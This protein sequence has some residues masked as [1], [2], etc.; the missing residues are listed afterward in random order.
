[1]AEIFLARANGLAGFERYVVLKRIRPER[2]ADPRWI[3]M[4]LDEARLAAQLQHPNVAQVYDLGQIGDAYFYTMEYVHGEDV[5]D[6]LSRTVA[7]GKKVPL[8]IAL[9]ITAGA[10]QGLGYAHDR[11]GVDGQPL[12]IVHRDIS[13]ANLMVSYDGT[14]K[15]LDFGVAKA[16][17]RETKTEAGTRMGKIAYLSP[18]Q[19]NTNDIDQR[20]DLFSLGVVLYEMVTHV[21]PF[22][23]Q[24]DYE[25]L[26]AIVRFDPPP[27]SA[28]VPG[29]PPEVDELLMKALAKDPNQRYLSAHDMLEGIEKAADAVKASLAPRDLKRFM[30]DLYGTPP[31]PWRTLA[32]EE[33]LPSFSGE[34]VGPLPADETRIRAFPA[35]ASAI[36]VPLLP[37]AVR[38]KAKGTPGATH[39]DLDDALLTPWAKFK[40]VPDGTMDLDDVLPTPIHSTPVP[41]M[42]PVRQLAYPSASHSVPTSNS[43]AHAR[44]S[45]NSGPYGRPTPKSSVPP[46][47]RNS[48]AHAL[49]TLID[50]VAVVMPYALQLPT[51]VAPPNRGSLAPNDLGTMEVITPASQLLARPYVSELSGEQAPFG[52]EATAGVVPIAL[53]PAPRQSTKW[54]VVI[55]TVLAI[56]GVGIGAML[57]LGGGKAKEAQKITAPVSPVTPA[58]TPTV[59]PIEEPAALKP[60]PPARLPVETTTNVPKVET[61]TEV[62]KVETKTEVPTVE[63]KTIP[64]KVE[65]KTPNV[66]TTPKTATP[67]TNQGK[68]TPANGKSKKPLSTCDDPLDC[69]H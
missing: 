32:S 66:T 35:D 27:P 51:R 16:R 63:T 54:P 2:D 44:A 30:R 37:G 42:A 28:V 56:V 38:E 3:T 46:P 21:R 47:L 10:V 59:T 39:D 5:L 25:T 24:S 68:T 48:D 4:F 60:T 20:S 40:P 9:A 15:V 1:M 31:E 34:V 6:V 43:G 45:H 18:E 52:Y 50:P 11:V 26:S 33:N 61:K 8:S 69:Q 7:L 14:V 55:V 12:A 67:K 53:A 17:S 65:T 41:P 49:P 23:R 19:C 13:P 36:E 58:A 62:P 57:A 64:T 22:K 29:L